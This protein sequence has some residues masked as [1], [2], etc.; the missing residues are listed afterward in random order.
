MTVLT[1]FAQIGRSATAANNFILTT[2]AAGGFKVSRGTIV[3]G[4]PTPIS[5]VMSVDSAG[6][7]SVVS[8]SFD[9]AN[10]GAWTSAVALVFPSTGGFGNANGTVSYRKLGRTVF[11]RAVIDIVANGT[12]GGAINITLPFA[13]AGV[14]QNFNGREG[15]L[16]GKG[17]IAYLRGTTLTAYNLD[18]TYPGANG[19]RFYLSGVYEATS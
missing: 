3:N 15:L 6:K 5:D 4:V 8:G 13:G 12:G 9:V 14:E 7:V 11:M 17:V 16:S 19:T 1:D 18:T 2:D 10:E